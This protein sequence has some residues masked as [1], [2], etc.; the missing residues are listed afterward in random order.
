MYMPYLLFLVFF[1]KENNFVRLP[2]FKKIINL[3]T[4]FIMIVIGVG[5]ASYYLL[6]LNLE[7]KYFYYG[8]IKNHLTPG[9]YLFSA[10]FFRFDWRYFTDREVITRGHIIFP[11]IIEIFSLAIG[12]LLIN[13]KRIKEKQKNIGLLEFAVLIS[14]FILLF[15][16]PLA[17]IFYE[18][19]KILSNIQFP[20]RLLSAFI[21]LPP[22]IYAYLLSKLNKNL[23]VIAF[24]I[25]VAVM[26]FPHLYGKN[27]TSYSK[28]NYYFTAFNPHS[29]LMNTIWSGK[30]EDYPIKKNNKVAIIEGKGKVTEQNVRNSSRSYAID[31]IT[32]LRLVDYTF[33]FPG[34]NVYIDGK[35]VPI[36]FQNPNYRGVI[37]YQVPEGKHNVNIKFEDTKVRFISKLLSL[38]SIFLLVAFFTF[39]K[40]ISTLL[41]LQYEAS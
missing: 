14:L 30:S 10:N 39:R 15:T 32:P 8:Q 36:E 23:L 31:A 5:M 24:I 1:D 4:L 19:I 17:S 25:I 33:Y 11:G 29:V 7:I 18:K 26:Q 40:K 9:S 37:T 21:F 28:D 35:S 20:W 27:Y 34:W 6:P 12:V 13:Y 41:N 22:I 3:G 16:T 38:F 2:N